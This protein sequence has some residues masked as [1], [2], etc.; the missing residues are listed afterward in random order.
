MP[1]FFH[2]FRRRKKST[3]CLTVLVA[4]PAT[5]MPMFVPRAVRSLARSLPFGLS[6]GFSLG[7]F[8]LTRMRLALRSH[9]NRTTTPNDEISRPVSCCFILSSISFLRLD[10]PVPL[11]ELLGLWGMTP[12]ICRKVSR[13]DTFFEYRIELRMGLPSGYFLLS[14]FLLSRHHEYFPCSTAGF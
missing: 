7:R 8:L 1:S 2:P 9:S 14:F 3:R 6:P 4:V 10:W 11:P 13:F 12:C 5:G